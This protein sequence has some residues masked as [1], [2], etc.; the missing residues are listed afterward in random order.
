MRAKR[1]FR[2]C[3]CAVLAALLCTS[4]FLKS[5]LEKDI[6]T[7]DEELAQESVPEQFEVTVVRSA[8]VPG[9]MLGGSLWVE[10]SDGRMAWL[11]DLAAGTAVGVYCAPDAEEAAGGVRT[12]EKKTAFRTSDGES[13]EF[14]HVIYNSKEYWVQTIFLAVDAL[15]GVSVVNNAWLYDDT[16]DSAD[17]HR[18]LPLG[19][20]VAVFTT[21][22]EKDVGVTRYTRISYYDPYYGLLPDRYVHAEEVST[23]ADDAVAMQIY[24]K[25]TARTASGTY[26]IRNAVV[27]AEL[28]SNFQTL[29]LSDEVKR[30]TGGIR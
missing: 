27:R 28:V 24:A 30:I 3:G 19:A 8:V 21:P 6:E 25:L 1:T 29:E 18:R 17:T 5:T 26:Q 10:R 4:C 12:A 20:M 14:A 13:R 22:L 16:K 2:L 7:E 9:V 23:R 15:P 11:H